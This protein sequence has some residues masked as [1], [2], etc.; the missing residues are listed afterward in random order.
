MKNYFLASIFFISVF[1][2]D[3]SAQTSITDSCG[4]FFIQWIEEFEELNVNEFTFNPKKHS[5]KDSIFKKRSSFYNKQLR[6]NSFDAYCNAYRMTLFS[7]IIAG[8]DTNIMNTTIFEYVFENEFNISEIKKAFA[9]FKRKQF[10]SEV[11]HFFKYCIL[12]NHVFIISTSNASNYKI[13]TSLFNQLY[14][15]LYAKSE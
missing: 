1:K 12:D 13:E 15:F 10:V 2:L 5:W 7:K 6:I 4:I 14:N 8:G 9:S 11:P 3:L